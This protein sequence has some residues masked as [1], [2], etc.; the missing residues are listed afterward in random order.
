ATVFVEYAAAALGM[1]IEHPQPY[2]VATIV[3]L[4]GINWFGIRA[5]S[6]TQNILTVLKLLAIC[7]LIVAGL[8]V[9]GAPP[10]PPPTPINPL[11]MMGALMPVLFSYGGWDS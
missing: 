7:A 8:S 4:T 10:A 1:T 3:F 5:G 6:L 11:T 9:G 2:A